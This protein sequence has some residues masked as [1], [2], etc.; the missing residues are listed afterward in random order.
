MGQRHTWLWWA[1]AG[2]VA[3]WLL[4][5]T[6]RPNQTVVAGLAPLTERAIPAHLLIDLAGN[7]AVFIPLGAALVLAL[8]DRSAKARLLLA[9]V[10]GASLSLTIELAQL[11]VPT[12]VTAPDDWL[13][14]TV[15]TA[16]G[17]STGLML[18]NQFL[19]NLIS[20]Q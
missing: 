7:V 9:T 13:L 2:A 5:M 3:A 16:L 12:R 10:A 15:G 6:L 20:R 18:R 14:N 4:W 11:L 17:A 1:L 8:G 19:K